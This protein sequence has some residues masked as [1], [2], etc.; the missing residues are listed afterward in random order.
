[1]YNLLS[2][3]LSNCSSDECDN[4]RFHQSLLIPQIQNN[5]KYPSSQYPSFTPDS[6]ITITMTTCKRYNLFKDTVHSFINCCQDLHLAKEWIV[7]DDNSSG[8][9]RILMKTNFPFIK[10]IFK[11]EL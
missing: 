8:Q 1:M 5:Y 2:N 11:N 7:I 6:N 3:Y 4:V 10:F 9:D